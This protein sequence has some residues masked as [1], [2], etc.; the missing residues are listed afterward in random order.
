MSSAEPVEATDHLIAL[1]QDSGEKEPPMDEEEV[2]VVVFEDAAKY[3]FDT[4]THLEQ[5]ALLGAET[6]VRV[7]PATEAELAEAC[8]A[9]E[10][11]IHTAEEG[12]P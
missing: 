1:Q 7:Q 11:S 10:A 2:S 12:R 4:H 8:T 9:T 3:I 6:F 5:W